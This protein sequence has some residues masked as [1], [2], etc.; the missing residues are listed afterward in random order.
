MAKTTTVAAPVDTSAGSAT[1]KLAVQYRSALD[2]RLPAGTIDD[3]AID[4]TTLGA[5]PL[6][7]T[8]PAAPPGTAAPPP[9]TLAEAMTEATTWI[10]AIHAAIAATKPK[11]AVRKA[12]GLSRKPVKEPKDVVATGQIIVTQAT[13]NPTEA[14]SLGVVPA[15]VTALSSAL[16]AVKAA[17]IVVKGSSG[18]G[19]T[20]KER[21]AAEVRM[22]EA[23]VRISGA[24]VLAFATNP[25]VRAEFAA[26]APPKKKA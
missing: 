18:G 22:H 2:P 11:A 14:L 19:A 12:Y 16:G 23:V 21:R 6:P 25:A 15:D 3:L 7:A 13:A 26:L 9:P 10:T 4:L 24:G 1:Y 5:A 20:A 8:P 17:E